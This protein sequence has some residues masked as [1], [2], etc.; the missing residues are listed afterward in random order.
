MREAIPKQEAKHPLFGFNP[1]GLSVPEETHH[2]IPKGAHIA[3]VR[4]YTNPL[5]SYLESG[6][7][8]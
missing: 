1:F 4:T 3:F 7:F 5:Q 8:L 2:R 6:I